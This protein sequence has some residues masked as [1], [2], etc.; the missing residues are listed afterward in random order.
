MAVHL[1]AVSSKGYFYHYEKKI[2]YSVSYPLV[3]GGHS[4]VRA[5]GPGHAGRIRRFGSQGSHGPLCPAAFRKGP[6]GYTVH[7]IESD[8]SSVREY[9]APSGVVFGIAWN[10]LIHPD[11][12]PLL[13]SYAVEY[14]AA[15]KQTPRK[16]GRRRHQVKSERV[17][18]EKWGH[19]RNLQGRDKPALWRGRYSRQ[20]P[21][22]GQRKR[23]WQWDGN[24]VRRDEHYSSGNRRFR[25]Q[26]TRR[27]VEFR[28]WR[29]H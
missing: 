5:A 21:V 7:E 28:V 11:L 4:G 3:F 17:I 26:S 9:M 14:R 27:G 1:A 15:L 19:M 2:L 24:L 13:G 12:T 22:R 10:G 18:V 6:Y 20:H 29:R 25:R 23:P 8:A 16:P